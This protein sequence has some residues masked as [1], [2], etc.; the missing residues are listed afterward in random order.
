MNK[1][2]VVGLSLVLSAGFASAKG[3]PE[4]KSSLKGDIE[5]K[6]GSTVKGTYEFST[7]GK[8]VKLVV[9]V[10][11]ATEGEHAVHI[12]EN[13]D[14]SDPE[15]KKAGGHWNPATEAHGQWTKEHHHLGDVGNMKVGKDGKGEIT[16]STD[17]WTLAS[18]DPKSDVSGHAIIV[19]E[20]IDD[21]TTQPT[22]NAGSR[23]GCGV[24]GGPA[25]AP[26]TGG[27]GGGT[28]GGGGKGT[29]GGTSGGTTT[30]PPKP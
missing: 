21:F 13:G 16:L 11:G 24:V 6:S 25:A 17:K 23:I 7:K 26:A 8:E 22:G 27:T 10:T 9:K 5:A 29:G 2:M 3:K 4:G 1:L 18:G 30:P 12:H 20:K 15:G 19:H 28:G 14:C